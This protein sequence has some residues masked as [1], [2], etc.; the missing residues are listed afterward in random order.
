MVV[1]STGTGQGGFVVWK[2][3]VTGNWNIYAALSAM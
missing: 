3:H 1:A 2:N